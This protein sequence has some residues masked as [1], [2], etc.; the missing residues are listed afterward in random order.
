MGKIVKHITVTFDDYQSNSKQENGKSSLPLGLRLDS[1]NDGHYQFTNYSYF[2]TIS[3]KNDFADKQS[4]YDAIRN[5][6]HFIKS[7]G[8]AEAVECYFEMYKTHD[9][10]H[11]HMLVDF[12]LPVGDYKYYNKQ[13]RCFKRWSKEYFK[14]VHDVKLSKLNFDFQKISDKYKSP[15]VNITKKYISKDIDIMRKL[16]FTP[17]IFWLKQCLPLVTLVSVKIPKNLK[18]ISSVVELYKKQLA[19]AIKGSLKQYNGLKQELN[20]K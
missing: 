16:N 14:M 12:H 4:F 19:S 18:R 5:Y 9:K 3:M 2:L 11:A 17:V 7:N 1:Q 13:I 10:L 20:M 15:D 6:L 8:F